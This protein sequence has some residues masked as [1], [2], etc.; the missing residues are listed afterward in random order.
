MEPVS[1]LT[2]KWSILRYAGMCV[3]YVPCVCKYRMYAYV[4]ERALILSY[5]DNNKRIMRPILHLQ[6]LR[7]V[8]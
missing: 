5:T 4:P 2:M 6:R 1:Y 8:L 3:Y 7:G